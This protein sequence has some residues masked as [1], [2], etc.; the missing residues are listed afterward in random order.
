MP[1]GVMHSHRNL[2]AV[3]SLAKLMYEIGEEDRMLS[4]LPLAHVAERAAVELGQLYSGFSVWFANNLTTFGDDLRRAQPTLFFAVPRIWTKFQQQV[5]AEI[6]A[7]KLNLMLKIPIVKRII[8]KK[9]TYCN[10][11]QQS[12]W[13]NQWGGT[14]FNL[15]IGMV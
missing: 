12:C 11:A 8:G 13:S 15:F 5:L 4:Y 3:A 7:K 1:K 14:N 2:G 9:T 10:G 6:P